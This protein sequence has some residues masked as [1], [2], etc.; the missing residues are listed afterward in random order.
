[1]L[2]TTST[3]ATAP[4]MD[5]CS[6]VGVDGSVRVLATADN[7]CG[8]ALYVGGDFTTAGGVTVNG[9]ARWDGREWSAVGG[10]PSVGVDGPVH[11]LIAHNDGGGNSLY[12]V[13]APTYFETWTTGAAVEPGEGPTKLLLTEIATLLAHLSLITAS[14]AVTCSRCSTR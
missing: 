9:L 14:P 1:M 4:K 10:G 12:P 5:A 3:P 11:A 7:G 8:P 13:S 6:A 2:N